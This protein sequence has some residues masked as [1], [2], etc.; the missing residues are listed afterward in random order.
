MSSHNG[1]PPF[2]GLATGQSFGLGLNGVPAHKSLTI[3]VWPKPARDRGTKAIP[4]LMQP[5]EHSWHAV[6]CGVAQLQVVVL[7]AAEACQAATG[8]ATDRRTR[9]LTTLCRLDQTQQCEAARCL[10]SW[11]LAVQVAAGAACCCCWCDCPA[12]AT[13]AAVHQLLPEPA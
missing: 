7:V 2:S 13:A 5:R 6:R 10:T 11:L 1:L 3:N 9:H 4:L 12:D 8:R